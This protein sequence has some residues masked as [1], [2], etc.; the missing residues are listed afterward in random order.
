MNVFRSSLVL[1]SLIAVG[2]APSH[3]HHHGHGHSP[4]HGIVQAFES[5]GKQA[6][7]AELKLHD[8]KGDLELWL[9]KDQ[10]GKLPYD[11]PL[12]SVV[13]VDFPKLGK[14]VKLQVRNTRKNEDEDGKGNI[15]AGKTNYFIFPGDT[16]VDPAFLVGKD[17]SSKV[18][19]S[20][21]NDGEPCATKTFKLQPHTH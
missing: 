14:A 9:T 21:S 1:L 5:G 20:F 18:V 15:R 3:H 12:N 2:C 4:H 16:G 10:A 11:L 19:V 6:G 17:F 13:T 8:D 7:F